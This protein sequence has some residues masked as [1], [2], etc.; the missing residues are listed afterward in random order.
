MI[1]KTNL[2][3]WL[4][5][6]M[7]A[8]GPAHAALMDRGGGMI[9]D[10]DLNITWLK[11]ANYAKTS[12]YDIDGKMNWNTANAW[13]SNLVYG[14]YN[15]WRLPSTTD[16]GMDGCNYAYSNTDCGFNVATNSSELAHLFFVELGNK[17]AYDPA[18]TYRGSL[19]SGLVNKSPFQNL[20]SD[21]NYWSEAF[22]FLPASYAW[23][24]NTTLGLQYVNEQYYEFNAWAVRNGDVAAVPE[25]T[26]ALLFGLSL[27]GLVATRRQYLRTS[28]TS[29]F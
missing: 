27:A 13:A 6:G 7:L 8:C 19:N 10:T 18:G 1:E 21:T 24:F 16:L 29:E 25:P 5:A 9:Y 3:G 11:D 17:S 22:S 28:R 2:A 12:G 4:V 20:Q 15:D 23:T 26:G 14:G